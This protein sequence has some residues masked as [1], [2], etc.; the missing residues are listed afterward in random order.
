VAFQRFTQL[1]AGRVSQLL[2]LSSLAADCGITQP[3]A[4]SWASVLEASFIAFRLPSYHGNI[5]KRLIKMPKLH[6]YDSGLAC[7]L[8]GI[9]DVAQLDVHPL[10][11]AIFESWVVSEIIKQRFNLGELAGRHGMGAVFP[12]LA[13]QLAFAVPYLAATYDERMFEELHRRAQLFEVTMGGDFRVE[14]RLSEFEIESQAAARRAAGVATEDED[15]GEEGDSGAIELPPSMVECL[16][17]N[18]SVWRPSNSGPR[19]G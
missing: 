1:S 16:R 7:W 19:D 15:L 18:L 9:R 17:V 8:L 2:N 4:K 3:T 12:W 13:L 10:R 11:G 5:S 6:F 14:G